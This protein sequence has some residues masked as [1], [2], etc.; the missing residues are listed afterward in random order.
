MNE[1]IDLLSSSEMT[2]VYAVA[3]I[4]FVLCMII[5][6][7]DKSYEK[8]KKKHNTKELNKLVE[9]IEVLTMEDEYTDEPV[10]T[11]VEPV[12]VPIKE[13]KKEEELEY[14]DIEPNK[15][16]AIRQLQELTEQLTKEEPVENIEL[17]DYETEQE[18]SA[19]ISLDELVSK[20]KEMYEANEI[21][22]YADE[23]NEPIS[24]N[25]LEKQVQMKKDPEYTKPFVVE[26]VV[27]EKIT[28]EEINEMYDNK[29]VKLDDLNTVK[30]EEPKKWHSSPIISPVFGI[31]KK[32]V[33][34]M[35]L[36][37]TAN[38][39]KLD[40]EIKKT[41]DFVMTLKDLQKHLD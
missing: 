32:E 41:N 29:T 17:T 36:E 30:V 31:E 3:L 37:N 5:Y 13:E 26:N 34:I 39:D 27:D 23:G 10:L 7:I 21:T 24:I 38:Y 11:P 4:A 33:S 28:K 16:E 12:I 8:R 14:T 1:L 15:E 6:I 9:Q 2:I 20:S 40:Q 19:I 18:K 25:D 35:E 22:Q